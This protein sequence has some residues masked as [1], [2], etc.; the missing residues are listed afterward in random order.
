MKQ[1]NLLSDAG[2]GSVDEEVGDKLQCG[3]MKSK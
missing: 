1:S 3:E 2:M